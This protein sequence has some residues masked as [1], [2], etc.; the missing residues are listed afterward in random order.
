MHLLKN[1]QDL[2]GKSNAEQH[3]TS[4]LIPIAENALPKAL[5]YSKQVSHINV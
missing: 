3:E 2:S 5:I 1:S 4:L